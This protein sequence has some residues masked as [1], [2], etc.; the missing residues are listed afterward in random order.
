MRDTNQGP[1]LLSNRFSA[2][3]VALLVDSF[4]ENG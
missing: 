2:F 1:K 3:L 4:H